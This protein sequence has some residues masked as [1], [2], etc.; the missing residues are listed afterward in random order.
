MSLLSAQRRIL[1]TIN[2]QLFGKI[3]FI[4]ADFCSILVKI[5]GDAV[6]LIRFNDRSGMLFVSDHIGQSQIRI[7]NRFAGSQPLFNFLLFLC[8]DFLPQVMRI[9]NRSAD[10]NNSKKS[11]EPAPVKSKSDHAAK[12]GNAREFIFH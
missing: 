7:Q 11:Q 12:V 6:V 10:N 9:V 3:I 1:R 2:F 8:S 4:V 5:T